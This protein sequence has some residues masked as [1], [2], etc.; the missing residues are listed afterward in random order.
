[1][2]IEAK[3]KNN[4]KHLVKV[5]TIKFETLISELKLDHNEITLIKID[6]EGGEKII[7]PDMKNYLISVNIPMWISLHPT[8]LEKIDIY[9]LV[10]ILFEIYNK[11]FYINSNKEKVALTKETI[12]EETDIYYSIPNHLTMKNGL[13]GT[14]YFELLFEK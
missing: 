3:W 10:N 6:I 11:C 13:P 12:L 2:D 5:N 14:R 9:M 1:L 7:I 8:F 4:H